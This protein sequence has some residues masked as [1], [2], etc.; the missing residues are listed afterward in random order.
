[1]TNKHTKGCS[2]SSVIREIQIKTSRKYYYTLLRMAV[3]KDAEELE[4]SYTACGNVK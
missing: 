1:M 2:T 4:V 3:G